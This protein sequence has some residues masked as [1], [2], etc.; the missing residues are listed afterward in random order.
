[1]GTKAD[2]DTFGF[3]FHLHGPDDTPSFQ[4]VPG[5]V[6][7]SNQPVH[8]WP[9][10]PGYGGVFHKARCVQLTLQ[11]VCACRLLA[12]GATLIPASCIQNLFT[13]LT[14]GNIKLKVVRIQPWYFLPLNQGFY[15]DRMASNK[16]TSTHKTGGA[17]DVL[18]S[19]RTK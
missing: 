9:C 8:W 16:E 19:D 5:T 15:D 3:S 10:L 4:T 14:T 18:V 7:K 1:M 13:G 12:S 11:S 17:T 6:A 2:I